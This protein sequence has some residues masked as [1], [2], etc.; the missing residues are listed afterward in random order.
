MATRKG[1]SGGTG[2]AVAEAKDKGAELVSAAQHQVGAKAEEMREEAGFQ[3]REQVEQR[4]T[5]VGEQILAV[6][7]ALRSGIDQLRTDGMGAPADVVDK[8]AGRVDDFGSYLKS[9]DAD[10]ILD[11]LEG[12]ARRRP[13]LTA[14]AAA[15]AGFMASRF[16]RASSDRRYESWRGSGHLQP[17][18]ARELSAPTSSP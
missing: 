17:S 5:Q 7:E 6:G 3:V 11:D 9:T 16:V 4:S 18:S 15:L 8:V 10:R 14:G 13:W 2:G 1:A 12:F